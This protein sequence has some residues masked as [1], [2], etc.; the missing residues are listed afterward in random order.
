MLNILRRSS[1]EIV[2]VLI[3]ELRR[4]QTGDEPPSEGKVEAPPYAIHWLNLPVL[5]G[6]TPLGRLVVLRDVTDE[7][8]VEQL[9]EDMTHMMVHDLRNPLASTLTALEFMLLEV[10]DTHPSEN[11]LEALRIAQTQAL[12][13]QTLVNR[14]LEILQLERGQMP[15]NCAPVELGELVAETLHLQSPLAE[16]R[17]IHLH[18]DTPPALPRAW[19]DAELIGRVL[20]NLVGNALKFTPAGGSVRLWAHLEG[21]E[22]PKLLVLVTDTGPGIPAEIQGRLFQKF[23]RGQQ[24]SRGNGLGLAFCKLVLEAHGERIWVENTSAQGTTIAFSLSPAPDA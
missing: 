15:V 2:R 16:A 23:V 6:Q 17:N 19:A 7:H 14:I 5:V 10:A 3:A 9:R 11:I 20:Q 8:A 13:M 1:H 24:E 18:L 4:V 22:Q 12:K 21:G